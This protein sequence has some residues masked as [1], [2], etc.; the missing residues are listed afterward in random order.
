VLVIHRAARRSQKPSPSYS[1]L[2]IKKTPTTTETGPVPSQPP[3]GF[4][5][6]EQRIR[7]KKETFTY[8]HVR[9]QV[10]VV[11]NSLEG[12]LE[13]PV[14]YHVEA[15]EGHEQTEVGQSGCRN[16]RA[17]WVVRNQEPLIG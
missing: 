12:A 2:F 15:D 4:K 3:T 5:I 17:G 6:D 1:I 14:V 10:R 16:A 8:F 11:R 9:L 13:Q 7:K